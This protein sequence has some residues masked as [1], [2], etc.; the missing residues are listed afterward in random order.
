MSWE[1]IESAPR[2]GTKI[3]IFRHDWDFAPVAKWVAHDCEGEGEGE[4][5]I[6]STFGGWG[7]DEFV[8]VPGA[9]EEGFLGW[10]ED[11]EDGHMPTHWTPMP[12]VVDAQAKDA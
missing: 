10:N 2:D 9:M 7:L 3:L 1:P 8:S 11:I 5:E 12:E 4:G 6:G